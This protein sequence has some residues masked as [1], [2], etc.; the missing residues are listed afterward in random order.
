MEIFL[1]R[2]GESESRDLSSYDEKRKI[3]D[4]DLTNLGRKQAK[5]LGD[6]LAG[7]KFDKIFSSN[8]S[9]AIS[10]AKAIAG[11]CALEPEQNA[12]FREIEFGCLA[13]KSWDE[14][15]DIYDEW[16]KHEKD[17]AYPGGENG[18]DVWSRVNPEL[19]RIAKEDYARIAIV[20]HGGTI[21]STISGLLG[22][23]QERRFDLGHPVVNCSISK[24]KHENGHFYVHSFNEVIYLKELV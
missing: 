5:A 15:S 13:T 22:I 6:A 3:Y 19:L 10:T 2:H 21:M 12:A 16:K 9:R 20:T 7:T 1:I 23:P 11:C 17:I 8:L 18:A 24:I 4:P 14:F